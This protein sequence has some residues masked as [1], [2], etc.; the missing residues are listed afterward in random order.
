VSAGEIAE[1]PGIGTLNEK[2]LHAGLKSWYQR[3]S[4]A[5][6]V[7]IDNY[8]VDI[9]RGD[10]LVEIQTGNFSSIKGKLLHLTERHPVRLVYPIALRKWIIKTSKLRGEAPLRRKSPKQGSPVDVFAELVS[11][12]HLISHRNFTLQVLMTL[13]EEVRRL[14]RSR[15]WRRRGWTIQERRLLK[16]VEDHVFET[17][18]D[19]IDLIPTSVM[20]PFSTSELAIAIGRPR[21]LA[22]KMAYC[23][24]KMGAITPVGKRK[25]A[26]LYIRSPI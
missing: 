21:W 11:F 3:D 7:N 22:Q 18:R 23:L 19:F 16:V 2:A 10:L 24:R 25:H 8:V 14:D 13:E 9:V 20:E 26:T 12:P 17:P 6:E 4:D 15:V 1:P 5:V